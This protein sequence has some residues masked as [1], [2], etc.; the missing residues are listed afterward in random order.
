MRAAL[1]SLQARGRVHTAADLENTMR[2][3]VHDWAAA[4]DAHKP[5]DDLM[6][7][8]TRADTREL[9]R[10]AREALREQGELQRERVIEAAQGPLALAEGDR[11]VITRN[12][13][14]LGMMNGDLA[15]VTALADRHGEVEITVQLDEGRAR[16][17]RVRDHPH[18]EHGYALT[19]HK[20]QGASVERAYVLA[21]ESMSAREWSYVAGSRARE[22]VH[23]YAERNTAD[24]LERI[25]ERSHKK[26]TALDHLPAAVTK[27][28]VE[29]ER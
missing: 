4:R 8:A 28:F 1:D 23:L 2:E 7:G 12:T 6:L 13:K 3:L 29:L 10:L 25:M 18:V 27:T 17:W 15:T 22:A 24:D 19:A 11:I 21:H 16:T 14:L 20:A 9:N 5:N 26:D